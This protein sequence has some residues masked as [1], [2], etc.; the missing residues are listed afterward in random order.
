MCFHLSNSLSP[1]G[2][3]SSPV[4]GETSGGDSVPV[5][6]VPLLATATPEYEDAVMRTLNAT[7]AAYHEFLRSEEGHGFNGQVCLIGKWCYTRCEE[8]D[9][10]LTRLIVMNIMMNL[11]SY[12]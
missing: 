3:D 5:G 2:L 6:A 7:N 4:C 8:D 12:G 11:Y 9:Y 10:G 1:Y